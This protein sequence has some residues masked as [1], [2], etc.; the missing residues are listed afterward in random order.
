MSIEKDEDPDSYIY[1]IDEND[2]SAAAASNPQAVSSET[3]MNTESILPNSNTSLSIDDSSKINMPEICFRV[4]GVDWWITDISIESKI[5]SVVK[6]KIIDLI[7]RNN[8]DN[9]KFE[10][11]FAVVMQT[12]E[13]E[14]LVIEKI[15]KINFNRLD[16]DANDDDNENDDDDDFMQ[17]DKENKKI[18][19]VP[20]ANLKNGNIFGLPDN[21]KNI[22]LI[23]ETIKKPKPATMLFEDPK[24]PIPKDLL[25][26]EYL[27]NNFQSETKKSKKEKNHIR[28]TVIVIE[29]A[30][31]TEIGIGI[32]TGIV[33]EIGTEIEIVGGIEIGIE[34]IMIMTRI[35][36]III[37]TEIEVVNMMT[38][39]GT[40]AVNMMTLIERVTEIETETGTEIVIG[41]E[42][43]IEIAIVIV[44]VTENRDIAMMIV[45]TGT[46]KNDENNTI[47]YICQM[48]QYSMKNNQKSLI[49]NF[50][51]DGERENVREIY[52]NK[53]ICCTKH[54]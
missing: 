53:L 15:K 48:F 49:F 8:P 25:S 36:L 26:T 14:L 33:I 35:I 19:V 34:I 10:G 22:D 41:T 27:N 40:E 39:T 50:L 1:G 47:Y 16:G 31:E 2:S 4:S 28:E 11:E 30:I 21:K 54:A 17:T 29:I 52:Y 6:G 12:D 42:T 46:A 3:A 43:E 20:I 13:P 32:V 7:M 9:G 5:N 38:M 37:K 24:N 44:I 45:K 23:R 51:I 18:E